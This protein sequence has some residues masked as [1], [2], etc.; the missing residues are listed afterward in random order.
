MEDS[1]R[2]GKIAAD[3]FFHLVE[4]QLQTGVDFIIESPFCF[5]EDV[6]RANNWQ[7]EYGV[8]IYSVICTID[9]EEREKRFRTRDRHHSHFD[10]ER[11]FGD[12]EGFDY[13]EMPGKQIIIET[14]SPVEKLVKKLAIEMELN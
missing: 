6:A 10:H 9:F 14:N 11:K 7:K 5:P 12:D 8:E 1:R 2:I 3:T 13:S 4:K